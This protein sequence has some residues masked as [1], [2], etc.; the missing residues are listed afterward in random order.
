MEA[1][2][3]ECCGCRHR[4]TS[5]RSQQLG[6]VGED[7]DEEVMTVEQEKVQCVQEYAQ[8]GDQAGEEDDEMKETK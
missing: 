5:P 7:G 1:G 2:A 8:E 6:V 3:T 4:H